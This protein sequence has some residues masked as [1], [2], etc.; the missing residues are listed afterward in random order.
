MT[1]KASIEFLKRA[2]ADN[3]H[4]VFNNDVERSNLARALD[5]LNELPEPK[6]SPGEPAPLVGGAA[7]IPP[8]RDAGSSAA[9]I[10]AGSSFADSIKG[11]GTALVEAQRELDAQS[12]LYSGHARAAGKGDSGAVP[13]LFRIP[14][15]TAGF[16]F[17]V[18]KANQSGVNIIFHRSTKEERELNEQSVELEIVAVPPPPEMVERLRTLLPITRLVTDAGERTRLARIIADKVWATWAKDTGAAGETLIRR[19]LLLEIAP[20]ERPAGDT[21]T[22]VR[23]YLG[24]LAYRDGNKHEVW[25]AIALIQESGTDARAHRILDPAP[26]SEGAQSG[27]VPAVVDDLRR[28]IFNI[29]SSYV[30][31]QQRLL[32]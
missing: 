12:M 30:D 6:K 28:A 18:T 3:G 22:T 4:I 31:A 13:T 32:S 19:S 27:A 15:L 21:V 29:A 23:R 8:T 11:L 7:A 20:L 26:V 10:A 9:D 1:V 5:R 17:A 24:V 16:K 2:L 25:T 14:K